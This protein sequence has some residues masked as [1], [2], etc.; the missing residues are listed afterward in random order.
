MVIHEMNGCKSN[1]FFH[2]TLQFSA[3]HFFSSTKIEKNPTPNTRGREKE[4]ENDTNLI[5]FALQTILIF[6]ILS[7]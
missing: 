6:T 7:Y 5:K 2:F 4:R 3:Y 1:T